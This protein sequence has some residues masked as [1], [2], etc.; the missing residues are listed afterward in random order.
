MVRLCFKLH[1]VVASLKISHKPE[2]WVGCSVTNDLQNYICAC[3]YAI[4]IAVAVKA[5]VCLHVQ[6]C[7]RDGDFEKC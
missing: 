2:M 3:I 7:D 6:Y 4:W 1:L 5:I